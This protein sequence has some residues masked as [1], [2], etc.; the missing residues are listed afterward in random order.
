MLLGMTCGAVCVE[1]R[2]NLY[3]ESNGG[4]ITNGVGNKKEYFLK[5]NMSV[6]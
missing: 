5:I 4:T 1:Y 6:L 2:L 3:M